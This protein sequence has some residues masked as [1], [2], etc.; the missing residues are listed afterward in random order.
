MTENRTNAGQAASNMA[1]TERLRAHL[2]EHRSRGGNLGQGIVD[3][4]RGIIAAG[5]L[6]PGEKLENE[7]N[8]AQALEVSRPTLRQAISVLIHDGLLDGRRG[9]GTFVAAQR[10]RVESGIEQMFSASALIR[11]AGHQVGTRDFRLRKVKAD[12]E[13][14]EA[15]AL[16]LGEPVA[17]ITRTRLADEE[18]LI[19]C[20]EFLPLH[21]FSYKKVQAFD[22][23][24]LYRFMAEE[25]D[26][27]VMECQTTFLAVRPK[28]DVAA[29]LG[30]SVDHPVLELR[31][32]HFS[33]DGERLLFARNFHN[34]AK[35]S[36]TARRMVS[37]SR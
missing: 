23:G 12:A 37:R 25:L 1:A 28:P 10:P 34:S 11:Q 5:A 22:G 9:V 29:R 19:V 4:F 13:V 36:F 17:A 35:T 30:I 33:A 24:S 31:Q 6:K 18:P 26:L 3:A 32:V 21:T 7:S 15:L 27:Q 14:A 16:P 8:L 20:F 2:R